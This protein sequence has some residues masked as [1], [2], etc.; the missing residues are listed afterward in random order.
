MNHHPCPRCNDTRTVPDEMFG[1]IMNC[2]RC[3]EIPPRPKPF[4]PTEA[5]ALKL[6]DQ[7]W[8]GRNFTN[9]A[10]KLGEECGEVLG[11]V[12]D[13]V[14]EGPQAFAHLREETADAVFVLAQLAALQE[15]TLAE[16]LA[17]AFTKNKIKPNRTPPSHQPHPHE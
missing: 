8:G 6:A 17:E 7:K 11:A 3:M 15:T 10:L 5:E 12:L 1:G 4:I 9:V 13:L 16:L 2:P 14:Q